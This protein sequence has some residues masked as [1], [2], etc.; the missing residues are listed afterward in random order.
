MFDASEA[1]G[2]NINTAEEF[3]DNKYGLK[4]ETE[5]DGIITSD[6]MVYFPKGTKLI[7]DEVHGPSG[8][9]T[10]KVDG[11]EALD[12]SEPFDA[13]YRGNILNKSSIS[14]SIQESFE[15]EHIG[16]VSN[17]II[18][19][20]VKP[21]PDAGIAFELNTLIQDEWEAIQGYNDAIVAAETEGFHDI[22]KVLKD[23]V[24]EENI[25]VGQLQKVLELVS[26]NAASI[27]EGEAEAA[28]QLNSDKGEIDNE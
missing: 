1:V 9:T 13:I 16:E 2:S 24:N 17:E 14:E 26:P 20:A 5:N 8:Y 23:I 15:D 12:F 28:E 3:L 25:H 10:F 6:A 7:I 11:K 19:D 21:G 18:P 4:I 27:G 22:A